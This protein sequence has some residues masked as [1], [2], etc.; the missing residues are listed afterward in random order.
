MLRQMVE[1][2]ARTLGSTA[3]LSVQMTEVIKDVTE[4]KTDLGLFRREHGEQH[5]GEQQSRVIARR[6]AIATFV[7]AL[8]AIESPL[9]YLLA[10]VH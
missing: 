10:H 7:A 5:A 4:V 1:A 2:N 6:W 3:G 9:L 8:A